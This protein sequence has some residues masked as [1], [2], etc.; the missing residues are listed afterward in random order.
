M[1]NKD[2]WEIQSCSLPTTLLF[3]M[4]RF[5]LDTILILFALC[6][7]LRVLFCLCEAAT[8][9]PLPPDVLVLNLKTPS[10]PKNAKPPS[11]YCSLFLTRRKIEQRK[12]NPCCEQFLG[13]GVGREGNLGYWKAGRHIGTSSIQKYSTSHS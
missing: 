11:I 1:H 6:H 9:L 10:P 12:E 3:F 2:H 4:E 8:D 5:T 7:L 13:V